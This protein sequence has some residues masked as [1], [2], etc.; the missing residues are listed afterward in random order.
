MVWS[1]YSGDAYVGGIVGYTGGGTATIENP[2]VDG[3]TITAPNGN[4]VAGVCAYSGAT[5]NISKPT[6]TNCSI[7]GLNKVSGVA[8]NT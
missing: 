8:N 3:C 4:L 2:V 6:V 1:T 7:I 5:V